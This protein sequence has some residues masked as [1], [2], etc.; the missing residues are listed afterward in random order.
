MLANDTS[1]EIR[2][3][4][5]P[6]ARSCRWYGPPRE[7][8]IW[9]IRARQFP[10]GRMAVYRAAHPDP[11][12]FHLYSICMLRH[13]ICLISAFELLY[14]ASHTCSKSPSTCTY[15]GPGE[16]VNAT[17]KCVL[18]DVS[19]TNVQGG[20]PCGEREMHPSVAF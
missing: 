15:G 8:N 7:K 10:T 14:K 2:S 17:T 1:I 18:R 3:L 19:V 20:T 16:A 4:P 11:G 6:P 12:V 9:K 13:T 5:E